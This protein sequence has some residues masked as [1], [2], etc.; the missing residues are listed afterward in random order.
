[1]T[2]AKCADR[3]AWIEETRHGPRI[4]QCERCFPICYPDQNPEKDEC[5]PPEDAPLVEAKPDLRP[6]GSSQPLPPAA[7]GWAPTKVQSLLIA[8]LGGAMTAAGGVLSQFDP[9]KGI[10]LNPYA[11]A[12]AALIGCATT[13]LGYS[14]LK[15]AGIRDLTKL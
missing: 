3:G 8:C 12:G 9:S 5:M 6:V 13:A 10:P 7:G 1:M 14:S 11:L 2:C 15:S 4:R